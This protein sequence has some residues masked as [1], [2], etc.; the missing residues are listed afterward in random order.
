MNYLTLQT[1]HGPIF[2]VGRLHAV[3]DNPAVVAV[4]GAF[5]PPY[6]L[7]DVADWFP[8]LSVLVAPIPGMDATRT[9]DF[10]LARVSRALDEAIET[11]LPN[12]KIVTLAVSAGALVTLGLRHPGIVHQVVVEPFFRTAPLWPIRQEFLAAMA[13]MEAGRKLAV[14]QIFG[15][16]AD[17]IEDRDY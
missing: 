7:H 3:G 8:G 1:T 17:R 9:I 16:G 11:L 6:F 5:P 14:D 13:D 12:R 4:G 10:D 2:V 15:V